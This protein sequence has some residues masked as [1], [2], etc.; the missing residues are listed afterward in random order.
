VEDFA[1]RLRRARKTKGVTPYRLAQ[2][3]GLSKQGI[4]N[5]EKHGADP[6]LSTVLKLAEALDVHPLSL[7]PGGAGADGTQSIVVDYGRVAAEVMPMLGEIAREL[8]K[9]TAGMSISLMME[10]VALIE[11]ALSR[12][13]T[14]A[15]RTRK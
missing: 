8:R 9:T 4:Y 10:R 3:T 11:R 14:P 15:A 12:L 2:L 7:L 5:L 13:L 6:H 1:T